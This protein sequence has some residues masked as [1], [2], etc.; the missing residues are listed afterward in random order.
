MSNKNVQTMIASLM[1]SAT[2]A[3]MSVP[4]GQV[5]LADTTEDS[6]LQKTPEQ[7]QIEAMTDI[8]NK[9][10]KAI[11]AA[12]TTNEI[13]QIMD[14][15]EDALGDLLAENEI[16]ETE[17]DSDTRAD[18]IPEWVPLFGVTK[19]PNNETTTQ[20][21]QALSDSKRT[22]FTNDAKLIVKQHL[23]IIN[24][25]LTLDFMEQEF[26]R[27]TVENHEKAAIKAIKKATTVDEAQA[28]IDQLHK[29]VSTISKRIGTEPIDTVQEDATN[30]IIESLNALLVTVR[31]NDT[32]TD[33]ERTDTEI[34]LTNESIRARNAIID[35]DEETVG[36][37]N[38]IVND[39]IHAMQTIAK[40]NGTAN[41]EK[42]IR[43]AHTK[44]EGSQ[45]DN[46]NTI[47]SNKTLTDQDKELAVTEIKRLTAEAKVAVTNA[48]TEA[49]A[50]AIVV[51]HTDSMVAYIAAV[52]K[53]AEENAKVDA[54]EL[55]TEKAE[56]KRQLGEQFEQ[57]FSKL[58]G[59]KTLTTKERESLRDLLSALQKDV[60]NQLEKADTQA[61]IDTI[62]DL[63]Q[64]DL[65]NY[66]SITGEQVDDTETLN[67]EKAK[68]KKVLAGIKDDVDGILALN[69]SLTEEERAQASIAINE[70]YDAAKQEI[71]GVSDVKGVNV[72]VTNAKE[73]MTARANASGTALT[74]AQKVEMKK[75]LAQDGEDAL[76]KL[77]KLA[78][79]REIRD[80]KLIVPISQ[81]KTAV[82]N[83][84]LHVDN[85]TDEAEFA[86]VQANLSKELE[87]LTNIKTDDNGGGNGGGNG[88][89]GDT[90][91][92]SGTTGGNSNSGT[93]GASTDKPNFTDV[94]SDTKTDAKVDTKD[95]GTK[96]EKLPQM[97]EKSNMFGIISG[98]LLM[99]VSGIFFMRRKLGTKSDKT[100][101]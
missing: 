50:K 67:K 18:W 46:L 21:S 5:V 75:K 6:E 45:T 59:N 93:T 41:T 56:A 52:I 82:L 72:A 40:E 92:G 36:E 58:D 71:E 95:A 28:I 60:Y 64:R 65:D 17:D 14:D 101:E 94:K 76:Q 47:N 20:V 39:A 35:L 33:A 84:Q 22:Q 32:L 70:I 90:G 85:V 88:G 42:T 44:L 3:T 25:N 15:T 31:A 81:I 91:N 69:K 11:E 26:D 83:A 9:S 100:N 62:L 53:D 7:I 74:D 34:R 57:A 79:E 80:S 87:K 77:K 38:T 43:D 19:T 29:D 66:T 63:T 13:Q 54:E 30:L 24:L 89:T 8:I 96:T 99:S 86:I 51:S 27:L 61:L 98:L 78:K 49:E 1:L 37:V 48:V 55:E 2:L 73:K 12:S 97:G 16:T 68:Q 4:I 10:L 23:A